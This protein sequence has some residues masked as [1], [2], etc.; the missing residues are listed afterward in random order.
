MTCASGTAAP[1]ATPQGRILRSAVQRSC[2]RHRAMR[3]PTARSG[4]PV[5]APISFAATAELSSAHIRRQRAAA[6][7]V[8]ERPSHASL[9]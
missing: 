1:R 5:S 4:A 7:A 3:H 6:A 8:S 9:D 2:M